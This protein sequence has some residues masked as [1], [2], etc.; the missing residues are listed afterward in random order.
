ML[1]GPLL[2]L[3]PNTRC[4]FLYSPR[5]RAFVLKLKSM[6]QDRIPIP[7]RKLTTAGLDSLPGPIA[8][9]GEKAAWRFVEFF[10]ANI[11]NKNTRAGLCPGCQPVLCLV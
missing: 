10:T 4:R 2:Q 1:L 6:T 8:R 11:R 3:Q 5:S 9:A 7:S